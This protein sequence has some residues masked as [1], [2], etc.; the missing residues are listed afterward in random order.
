MLRQPWPL[1]PIHRTPFD[2]AG[3]QADH[4]PD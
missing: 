4:H 2:L 3:R 1:F